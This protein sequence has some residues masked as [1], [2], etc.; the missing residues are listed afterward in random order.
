VWL[1]LEALRHA[2]IVLDDL[3]LLLHIEIAERTRGIEV[4]IIGVVIVPGDMILP[5]PE[6]EASQG[7]VAAMARLPDMHHFMNEHGG[8]GIVLFATVVPT[9]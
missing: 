3:R 2:V 4:V 9:P 7:I 6:I 1:G 5:D 8:D